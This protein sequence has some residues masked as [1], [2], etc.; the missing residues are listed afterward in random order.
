MKK[1]LVLVLSGV[2]G[3][4]LASVSLAG[5]DCTGGPVIV[6]I[7]ETAEL[8]E[9]QARIVIPV[10]GMTCAGCSSA[11]TRVVKNL[12]GVVSVDVNY[13]EGNTTVVHE[14]GRVTVEQIVAAINKTGYKASVP[15]KG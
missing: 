6:T 3:L 15:E 9:G 2:A 8:S 5:T 1:I 10:N 11:I 13:E 14:R 4:M 12:E 7:A